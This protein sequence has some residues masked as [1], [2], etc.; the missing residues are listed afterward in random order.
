MA[1]TG[2]NHAVLY[3]RNATR[4][5]RFYED[6]LDFVVLEADREGK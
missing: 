5:V 1:I 3:V 2:L 4:A 6:V